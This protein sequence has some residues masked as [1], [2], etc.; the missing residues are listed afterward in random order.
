MF[1]KILK[2][3]QLLDDAFRATQQRTQ[4]QGLKAMIQTDTNVHL[5]LHD[6]NLRQLV[7]YDGKHF[8]LNKTDKTFIKEEIIN[9]AE[10]QPEL[11]SNNVVTRP[12]MEE[13]LFNTVAFI[14]GPSEIKYWAELKDVFELFDVEM[15]I[16]MPRLRITYLNDRI[17]KLLS[18]Y[19]I[20]LEKVL[21]DGVEGERSKFIREQASDQFIEKVE[22]MIE[23]QR[24]LYQDLLDEVAGN[25]NNINLVNKNNEIHIQ[26]YDYLLKRYLLNIERENDISMKQFREIQE[27]LHPMGGLQERIWNPLQ[28]LNDFGT[29][30][31][32]PST[33]PPL[34]YTF[35]HIVIKP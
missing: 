15:P 1:K 18:K 8:K 3:H 35:D 22:G 26:Q 30:V 11:F 23:Q 14:G 2:K 17:E 9:I 19:N 25:Q 13:W 5:F 4:N 32:K 27:T 16:V 28:I 21:V 33:Y 20:P 7:S 12:L 10:N 24:R 29:D 6:E 34:S 31:F